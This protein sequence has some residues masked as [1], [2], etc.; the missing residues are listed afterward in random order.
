[1]GMN[2]ISDTMT[3]AIPSELIETI[4]T[5]E[6]WGG[7]V[8]SGVRM[9]MAVGLLAERAISLGKAAHLAGVG[10]QEFE[11]FLRRAGFPVVSYTE[12]EFLQD[13]RFVRESAGDCPA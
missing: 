10:I 7:N 2:S 5:H 1:M 11:A 9:S 12:V 13:L 4:R 6:K 3:I 8:E